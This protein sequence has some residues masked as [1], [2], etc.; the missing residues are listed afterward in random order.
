MTPSGIHFLYPGIMTLTRV[1]SA[2][3][4]SVFAKMASTLFSHR[5]AI[6]PRRS[7]TCFHGASYPRETSSLSLSA[8][9]V[10]VS[11][12]HVRVALV[13]RETLWQQKS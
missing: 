6:S 5:W 3:L 2:R 11:Q 7:A 1:G 4:A 12:T 8:H 13:T 10:T 9:L